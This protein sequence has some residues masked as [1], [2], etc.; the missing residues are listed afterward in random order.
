MK[1]GIGTGPQNV[2]WED[3]SALWRTVDGLDYDSAWVFDHLLPLSPNADDP[4]LEGWTTLDDAG[5][6]RARDLEN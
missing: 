4:I 1:F 2:S 6:A 3:L 5:R